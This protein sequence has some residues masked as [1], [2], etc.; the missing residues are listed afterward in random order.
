MTAV[1]TSYGKKCYKKLIGMFLVINIFE[2][3]GEKPYLKTLFGG[4]NTFTCQFININPLKYSKLKN[5]V[6]RRIGM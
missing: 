4:T 3:S 5:R 2:R 1:Q 6:C